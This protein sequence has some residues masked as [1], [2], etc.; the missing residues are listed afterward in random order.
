[1]INNAKLQT[2]LSE[3]AGNSSSKKG[4]SL[5]M[6][7]KY[8][9]KLDSLHR[10]RRLCRKGVKDVKHPFVWVSINLVD[11]VLSPSRI[12]FHELARL[13]NNSKLPMISDNNGR[14]ESGCSN[15]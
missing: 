1:L 12:A 11:Q 14:K 9:L 2:Y 4:S 10:N 5:K 8:M 3:V 7:K 13:L 15:L 6:L